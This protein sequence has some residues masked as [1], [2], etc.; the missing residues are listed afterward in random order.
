MRLLTAV[1]KKEDLQNVLHDLYKTGIEGITVSDVQG[2]GCFRLLEGDK[3]PTNLQERVKLELLVKS[4]DTLETAQACIRD[5]CMDIAH[6]SGKMWWVPVSG[7]ERIRTGE[8]DED[9]L[10]SRADKKCESIPEGI[11]TAIDTPCS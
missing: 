7:I 2:R 6:G 8:R 4:G 10:T 3:D 11:S 9:A 5:N 1:I